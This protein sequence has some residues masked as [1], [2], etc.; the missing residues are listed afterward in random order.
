MSKDMLTST[1]YLAEIQ[2]LRQKVEELAREKTDLEILLDTS[3]QHADV[4]E[5]ELINAREIA[6]KATHAKSEFLA[7]MSHEIRTPLNGIV[8]M[9]TLLLDTQLSTEQQDYVQTIRQSSEILLTLI[10]DILDFSK[11]E[12]NK[13]D[14]E[15]QSFN[16]RACVEE[17][18]DMVAPQ[19]AQK[20]LNLAYFM[21][22]KSPTT[23][24][25]DVT[26]LRQILV[27]LLSNAVKFTEHGEVIVS[28]MSQAVEKGHQPCQIHF[29][30][31]DTGI[32]ISPEHTHRLFQS[33]T[34]ADT[35][36]TRKYG[37]T[38]LGLAICKRLCEAMGGSI[39]LESEVNKGSAFHFTVN[40]L[41]ERED[42]SPEHFLHALQPV[43]FGKRLLIGSDNVTNRSILHKQTK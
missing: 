20:G 3:A 22:D 10:S 24:V 41:A 25:G 39:W 30:V 28:V 7:N 38:G 11:I 13:L 40:V 1:D 17:A 12:A 18:L 15:Q 37:G 6:E 14:L 34:Q 31:Q 27:N 23:L 9:T 33:F 8:G 35:S 2:Q 16:L 42:P 21:T 32:G 36:T 29:I 5:N 43:L 4:I 26:R 19:A